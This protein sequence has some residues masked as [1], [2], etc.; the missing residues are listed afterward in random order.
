MMWRKIN[1]E[2]SEKTTFNKRYLRHLDTSWNSVR[3]L[4]LSM[5]IIVIIII[6]KY[7]SCIYRKYSDLQIYKTF[8][9]HTVYIS[10][11]FFNLFE[12]FS[13][14]TD[15]SKSIIFTWFHFLFFKWNPL[16][17][18]LIIKDH[19]CTVLRSIEQNP[20]IGGRFLC[21]I[22]LGSVTR[23]HKSYV[24]T[25]LKSPPIS[26]LSHAFIFIT[27]FSHIFFET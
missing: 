14:V 13:T 15:L 8:K 26:R 23:Q 12:I 19:N 10:Q 7:L 25:L 1:L 18:F 16:Y 17:M 9:T 11:W 3:I 2:H 27:F 6:T 4:D 5:I 21:N 24:P 20:G 22:V